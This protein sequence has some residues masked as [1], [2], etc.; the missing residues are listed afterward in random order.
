MGNTV[1]VTFY[2]GLRDRDHIIDH[3]NQPEVSV[4]WEPVLVDIQQRNVSRLMELA[5]ISP[6]EW[7]RYLV[8]R[9]GFDV[10][11]P[12]ADGLKNAGVPE[13]RI[14]FAMRMAI[15]QQEN[16]AIQ[17]DEIDDLWS[18]DDERPKNLTPAQV[19]EV[20]SETQ[21]R[22][23]PVICFQA[24]EDDLMAALSED[25]LITVKGEKGVFV[26]LSDP[27][28][29]YNWS[30]E[31]LT[32]DVVFRPSC[33]GLVVIGDDHLLENAVE[34]A[35]MA[36][37]SHTAAPEVRLSSRSEETSRLPAPVH[38]DVR[39]NARK[40]MASGMRP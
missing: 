38:R 32:T 20:I 34:D 35:Y 24:D 29:G 9:F 30:P 12:T 3:C 14:E 1:A 16:W 15:E 23:T 2:Q 28:N 17:G 21:A 19:Y 37:I 25:N 5:N 10:T 7:R 6:S 11:A 4:V 31:R 8:D 40:P 36:S 26:G 22:G 33:D 39:Q 27:I 18:F 13:H